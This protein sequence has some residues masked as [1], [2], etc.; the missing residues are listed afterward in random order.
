MQHLTPA[1]VNRALHVHYWMALQAD[2]NIRCR[3][4]SAAWPRRRRPRSVH[5]RPEGLARCDIS[6]RRLC[7]GLQYAA[8]SGVHIV[9]LPCSLFEAKSSP[10]ASTAC[11]TPSPAC[12]AQI[13]TPCWCC[14][15]RRLERS[16]QQQLHS[17]LH[18]A[19]PQQA[20]LVRP[21]TLRQR[22]LSACHCRA[23]TLCT[24]YSALRADWV[25]AAAGAPAAAA[26]TGGLFGSPQATQPTGGLFGAAQPQPQQAGGGLFG[27][28]AAQPSVFGQTAAAAASPFGAAAQ[29]QQP[30]F[31]AL[32]TPAP[33][34]AQLGYATDGRGTR[35]APFRP[36]AVKTAGT[37]TT[38]EST[39]QF[40]SIC[41][42]P[43]YAGK[44][45][46][47]LRFE[48]YQAGCKGKPG[49]QLYPSIH[50]SK[51]PGAPPVRPFSLPSR[52]RTSMRT[53][54][55]CV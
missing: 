14:S 36:E 29:P 53:V 37:A 9:A 45:H 41:A 27:A 26:P 50:P 10:D 28:P 15:P 54:I 32:G 43:Q 22:C 17:D 42:M 52:A 48:D 12:S 35:V 8:C 18:S 30:S 44:S 47:E 19:S 5:Q 31:G 21:A 7:A 3:E 13:L 46:E 24:S 2:N 38:A 11:L 33:N 23:P 25:L 51:V 49:T 16:L 4:A 6:T 40:R 20:C 34:A 39:Q 1:S 55:S